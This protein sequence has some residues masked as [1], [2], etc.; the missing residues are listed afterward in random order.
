MAAQLHPKIDRTSALIATL[1]EACANGF[2]RG[3]REAERNNSAPPALALALVFRE[4]G[5]HETL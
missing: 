2:V 5:G 1:P 3:E 4:G